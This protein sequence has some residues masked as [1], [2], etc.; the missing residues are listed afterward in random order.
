MDRIDTFLLGKLPL[1]LE[2]HVRVI[3]NFNVLDHDCMPDLDILGF[4]S[5]LISNIR[6]IFRIKIHSKKKGSTELNPKSKKFLNK[7]INVVVQL[8]PVSFL[9][10]S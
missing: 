5:N 9:F 4:R 7:S 6:I 1:F 3:R 10:C 2:G 8:K